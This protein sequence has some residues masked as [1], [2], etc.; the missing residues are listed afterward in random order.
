MC[1]SWIYRRRHGC[2]SCGRRTELTRR[3]GILRTCRC[4][5]RQFRQRIGLRT[6]DIR[7]FLPA[8]RRTRADSHAEVASLVSQRSEPRLERKAKERAQGREE[9]K[10]TR[11][12]RRVVVANPGRLTQPVEDRQTRAQANISATRRI[13]HCGNL[14]K[15][16]PTGET[17]IAVTPT[18]PRPSVP[19]IPNPPLVVLNWIRSAVTAEHLDPNQ[20]SV[21]SAMNSWDNIHPGLLTPFHDGRFAIF[22]AN[23]TPR[24]ATQKNRRPIAP[25]RFRVGFLFGA[26]FPVAPL[27][28]F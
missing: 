14:A 16:V 8:R 22:R 4:E 20:P 9:S 2:L 17:V 5:H 12:R 26:D 27:A 13:R 15:N 23:F 21:T 1:R 19:V 11:A 10:V 25:H 28:V 3:I 18:A 7:G 6:N 24:A